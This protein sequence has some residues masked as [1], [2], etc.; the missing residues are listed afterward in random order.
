[1]TC[2]V[3]IADLSILDCSDAI[4]KDMLL[5]A[6]MWSAKNVQVWAFNKADAGGDLQP[7]LRLPH[8]REVRSV[9]FKES[10]GGSSEEDADVL[11]TTCM[12]YTLRFWDIDNQS[13][14]LAIQ[15][16]GSH[17]TRISTILQGQ[18]VV[19]GCLDGSVLVF[20]ALTGLTMRTMTGHTMEITGILPVPSSDGLV[21]S[22]SE[23]GS[24]RIWEVSRFSSFIFMFRR[25]QSILHPM[26]VWF[27]D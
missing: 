17:L 23:D 24:V 18:T 3:Q 12:D 8:E 19:S 1:M 9:V 16:P 11:L 10:V 25:K 7:Y 27:S 14:I 15:N 20:D 5:A 22:T 26:C 6:A 21:A 4:E 13:C 2:P